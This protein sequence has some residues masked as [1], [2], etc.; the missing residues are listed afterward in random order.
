MQIFLMKW[1]I[2]WSNAKKASHLCMFQNKHDVDCKQLFP[3]K[4]QSR[5]LTQDKYWP[6]PT[7]HIPTGKKKKAKKKART[8]LCF[9]R[10][11]IKLSSTHFFAH[12]W[13]AHST[14]QCWKIYN[15]ETLEV[16]FPT[17]NT[18]LRH[19]ELLFLAYLREKK[20]LLC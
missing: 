18:F 7:N 12:I 16:H 9:H 19:V 13:L 1:V 14:Q 5:S 15:S 2:H 3:V 10:L 17:S 8:N 6:T 11:M 4:E 20:S